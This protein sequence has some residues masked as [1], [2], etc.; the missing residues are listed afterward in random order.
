MELRK[1]CL[2]YVL[3]RHFSRVYF[4]SFYRF[5]RAKYLQAAMTQFKW[6]YYSFL[7]LLMATLVSSYLSL[8]F[9]CILILVWL[10]GGDF[11]KKGDFLL[12]NWHYP[13]ITLGLLTAFWFLNPMASST[14]RWFGVCFMAMPLIVPTL[15]SLNFTYNKKR[16]S[17]VF[18]WAVIILTVA[19]PL[20]FMVADTLKA[21]W[22]FSS[23]DPESTR[24]IIQNDV[25][26]HWNSVFS[27]MTLATASILVLE[28]FNLKD[29]KRKN[30]VK[31]VQLCLLI[32]LLLLSFAN[33]HNYLLCVLLFLAYGLKRY[34]QKSD[35]TK[36]TA[37]AWLSISIFLMLF[38][39]ILHHFYPRISGSFG[40][41]VLLYCSDQ[42]CLKSLLFL[43]LPTL[44]LMFHAF[45]SKNFA[46]FVWLISMVVILFPPAQST[47]MSAFS[48]ENVVFIS[49]F[50][51][52][53]NMLKSESR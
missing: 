46:F 8:L 17:H 7:G 9:L 50:L 11:R 48:L 18:V 2:S 44:L 6:T 34:F 51:P 12:K 30:A 15:K 16:F 35:P 36:K 20:F 47:W 38:P 19:V 42:N 1:L 53:M 26:A 31:I 22:L 29:P 41:E 10:R 37:W 14:Q 52:L 5:V 33:F 45:K 27:Q 23:N 3:V 39:Y 43:V 49:L 21:D 13:A 24:T 40:Y 25:F 4:V 28:F 32:G